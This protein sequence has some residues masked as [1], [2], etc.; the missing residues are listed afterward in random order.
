M[1]KRSQPSVPA[2]SALVAKEMISAWGLHSFVESLD[3]LLKDTG[4]LSKTNFRKSLPQFIFSSFCTFSLK[5]VTIWD[6]LV[7]SSPKTE[8]NP[9][10]CPSCNFS[11]LPG[12][13]PQ[14]SFREPCLGHKAT[15]LQGGAD[16]DPGQV[17]QSPDQAFA[18]TVVEDKS[19][20]SWGRQPGRLAARG[21]FQ[22]L[23]PILLF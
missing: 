4:H 11:V 17:S 8:R 12:P 22:M 10:V 2:R 14:L 23:K 19:S 3:L 6:V 9:C 20:L 1:G 7:S 5:T 18:I 21:T 16:R 15:W 13:A